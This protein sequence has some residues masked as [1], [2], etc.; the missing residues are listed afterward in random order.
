MR[1]G[2]ALVGAGL[3]VIGAVWVLQGYG[4]I[5]GSFMT[6]SPM[7]MWIGVACVAAGLAL[8]VAARSSGG[9]GPR[10]GPEQDPPA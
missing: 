8:I 3:I 10:Q 4:T 6:G 7:W 1:K 2:R 9:P 5:T